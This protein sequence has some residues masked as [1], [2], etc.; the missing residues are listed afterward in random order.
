MRLTSL[1]LK[2]AVFAGFLLSISIAKAEKGWVWELPTPQG[3]TLNATWGADST[4]VYAVGDNG[5]IMKFDGLEWTIQNPTTAQLNG[6]WG[7]STSDIYAV[8]GEANSSSSHIVLHFDGTDWQEL[9]IGADQRLYAV[10]G[11]G[12]NNIYI[13]GWNGR[14]YHYNGTE[15]LQENFG[16]NQQINTIWGTATDNIFAVGAKGTI[17]RFNGSYWGAMSTPSIAYQYDIN[18]IWGASADNIFAVGG[19]YINSEYR[20]IILHFNG[21]TW[22]TVMEVTGMKLKSIEGVSANQIYVTTS[23][24]NAEIL[25]FDGTAWTSLDSV[26]N[27]N[28][29]QDIW[30]DNLGNGLFVGA[31]G[32]MLEKQNDVFSPLRT[33]ILERA[34]AI[35]CGI[36]NYAAAVTLSG[37]ILVKEGNQWAKI[38]GVSDKALYSVWGDSQDNLYAVGSGGTIVHYD[39]S[40]WLPM[41]SGT[42]KTLYS[43]RGLDNGNVI[44][45][46]NGTILYFNGIAWNE[47]GFNNTINW[48]DVWGTSL[49]NIYAVS[50]SGIYHYNGSTWQQV[51]TQFSFPLANPVIFGTS[52]DDIQVIYSNNVYH[53]D[54]VVWTEHPAVVSSANA[55][56]GTAETEYYYAGS[57][58]AVH[59]FNGNAWTDISPPTNR[60]LYGLC[61]R[62]NGELLVAG[63]SAILRYGELTSP[64]APTISLISPEKNANVS[65]AFAIE[66][67]AIAQDPQEGDISANINWTSSI[68]GHLGAGA[69]INTLL[70]P[71]L[72][73]ISV[74]V[75]DSDGNEVIQQFGLTVEN[76][77]PVLSILS[78]SPSTSFETGQTVDYAATAADIEDGNLSSQIRWF[79]S[80]DG[81]LGTGANLSITALNEG[82]HLISSY[83]TDSG[84]LETTDSVTITVI[85]M[86]PNANN[87]VFSVNEGSISVLS[88]LENDADNFEGLDLS[89]I[90]LVMN[91]SLGS[92]TIN[93]DGTVS[94]LHNGSEYSS[95]SFA[96]TVADQKGKV[97]NMATVNITVIPVNDAPIAANDSANVFI[98]ANVTIP[99]IANDVDVDS[100]I[101]P[102]SVTI[103]NAPSHGSVSVNSDG[104]IVYTHGGLDMFPD[105][106]TYQI[107]DDLGALSNIATVDINVKDSNEYQPVTYEFNSGLPDDSEGWTY[108]SSN[109]TYGRID[110]GYGGLRMDVSTNGYYNLN[111]AIYRL[112]LLGAH[113][114]VLNFFQADY[115]DELH[116]MPSTF[117]GHHN[118]DGVAVSMDGVTWYSAMASSSLETTTSGSTYAIDLDSLVTQIQQNYDPNFKFTENFQ[119]KFQQ[120]DNYA[121]STD[122]RVWDNIRVDASFSDFYVEVAPNYQFT[123]TESQ[124]GTQACQSFELKNFSAGSI[125]WSAA[126]NQDWLTFNIS[127]GEIPTESSI[128]IEACWDMNGYGLGTY[129]AE[130][131]FTS[132]SEVYRTELV[133]S[134]VD[135]L[136][137][138]YSM[139]FTDG[140]PSGQEWEFYSSSS[141]G[142]ISVAGGLLRMD[143]VSNGSYSLNE[144]ILT[145]DLTSL[146]NI[147]LSFLQKETSDEIHTMPESFTG[148]HSSDGVA[149]SMDGI[150]WYRIVPSVNLDVGSTGQLFT[151]NLDAEVARIK[152]NL[153][154]SFGYSAQFKVKFQQYDNYSSPTDGREWDDISLTLQ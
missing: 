84:L 60:S 96:Y 34:E 142:R 15:W 109:S 94:Y 14:L 129:T 68:S 143:V 51:A 61:V 126:S 21:S 31:L 71:G 75:T 92:V 52:Q 49:D 141:N 72:H 3:N 124:V 150:T 58:G 39:G 90:N 114:V 121:T 127:S 101:E 95:D 112:D 152:T 79:S 154:P 82:S 118:S 104:S 44:A 120:Y 87:D 36:D 40:A 38:E 56:Q 33:D 20:S 24:G 35:W 93:T 46:G 137:L 26:Q 128:I 107:Q 81:A 37:A 77:A 149:I 12:E 148:H 43:V 83:V 147:Q 117:S 80:L 99:V 113:D 42:T 119:I 98:G 151:I 88:L 67:S 1:V 9:E 48:N 63:Q 123:M 140:M 133:V 29:I 108:Y 23:Q 57:F 22:S 53:Y 89:S 130:I 74:S 27:K 41:V 55:I 135:Q 73:T 70:P 110:N 19:A 97:S 18:D 146:S 13:G 102:A 122:G 4:S 11:T 45:A 100:I 59:S 32:Y 54:G 7:S 138:P 103:V 66:F 25:Y 115:N 144:A 16:S 10:W 136:T 106:F 85:N 30:L 76:Q 28:H 69:T 91:P 116:T 17:R 64:E 86:P 131:E 111:E 78:P 2:L 47:I 125:D 8:G 62:P 153:D 50:R 65:P 132:A 134:I 105:S 145:L 5:T 6:L 139:N